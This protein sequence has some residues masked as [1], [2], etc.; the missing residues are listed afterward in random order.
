MTE[1]RLLFLWNVVVPNNFSSPP[2]CPEKISIYC[3]FV[4]N[5]VGW[6]S[7][8]WPGVLFKHRRESAERESSYQEGSQEGSWERKME[9]RRM[10][11][12]KK[13]VALLEEKKKGGRALCISLPCGSGTGSSGPPELEP[14]A[15]HTLHYTTFIE[16]RTLQAISTNWSWLGIWFIRQQIKSVERARF[17]SKKFEI[18][19]CKCFNNHGIK[20]S[21][22]SIVPAEKQ[23]LLAQQ[24]T[25]EQ[26]SSASS[27]TVR[28]SHTRAQETR[29][30]QQTFTSQ[31]HSTN[32]T[33]R[34]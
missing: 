12:A 28:E 13:K 17:F 11:E 10:R 24:R 25:V 6:F 19:F 15:T 34:G 4:F 16:R 2:S 29:V 22:R 9:Y 8:S 14:W 32:T 23:V 3:R 5:V 26:R 27:T 7:W 18:K 33:H 31:Q 30:S 1:C 21:Q 20:M